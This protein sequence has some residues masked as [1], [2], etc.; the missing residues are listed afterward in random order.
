[1][2]SENR[3]QVVAVVDLRKAAARSLLD[4]IILSDDIYP[5]FK[6]SAT[7]SAFRSMA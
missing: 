1:M 6:M 2:V 4:L 7:G 3:D 5:G